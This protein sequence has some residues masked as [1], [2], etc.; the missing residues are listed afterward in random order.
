MQLGNFQTSFHLFKTFSL[1]SILFPGLLT[2][3]QICILLKNSRLSTSADCIFNSIF[4]VIWLAGDVKEPKH[5]SQ[6][7]GHGAPGVVVWP[8]FTKIDYGDPPYK[9]PFL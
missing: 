4:N 3:L 5:Y 8:C 2:S 9:A 6:R 7:V 1:L